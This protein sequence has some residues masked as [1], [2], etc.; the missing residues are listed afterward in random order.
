[1]EALKC[2][3]LF[4]VVLNTQDLELC[5]KMCQVTKAITVLPLTRVSAPT[6]VAR[7]VKDTEPWP[8]PAAM[9]AYGHLAL[10]EPCQC[11]M[12]ERHPRGVPPRLASMVRLGYLVHVPPPPTDTG[13]LASEVR[14]WGPECQA[15]PPPTAGFTWQERLSA[16]VS[17]C[18]SGSARSHTSPHHLGI[19]IPSWGWGWGPWLTAPT[20]LEG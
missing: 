1:M 3:L 14:G 4:R 9:M 20:V 7:K 6:H 17:W 10:L 13:G 19:C 11:Q 16:K 12:A 5:C 15:I 2:G 18:W 8:G